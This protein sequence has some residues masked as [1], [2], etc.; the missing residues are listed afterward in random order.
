MRFLQFLRAY[1]R[2]ILLLVVALGIMLLPL[3]PFVVWMMKGKG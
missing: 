3:L 2:F 1:A